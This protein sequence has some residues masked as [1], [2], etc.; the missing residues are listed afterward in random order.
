MRTKIDRRPLTPSQRQALAAIPDLKDSMFPQVRATIAAN[1]YIDPV[2][3]ETEKQKVFCRS[4]VI[5]GPSALLPEPRSYFQQELLGT[6]VLVTR[7]AEREVRAFMNV[8]RHRGALLCPEGDPVQGGRIV[9]RYHA[10]TYALDGSLTG[11][12]RQE[13]FP[14][15]DKKEHHLTSLPC[16]EAGGFIW[17]GLD[18]Q[19]DVDFATVRGE[20]EQDLDA[21]GLANMTIFDRTTFPIQANWKLV[22][23]TMLDSYHVTRLHKNS[24]ARFFVDAQNIVDAI[25]PH[26]RAAAARGNFDKRTVCNDFE[27]ARQIMVFAYTLFPN[28][29]VVCSPD[30]I[31]V[32]VLRPI[33]TDRSAVD[34]YMLINEPAADE[35][36]RDKLRRSFELMKQTFG[37]EDYW[38]AELCDKGL[39][40]GTLKE[41]QLGGMEVQIAMFHETIAQRLAD[42]S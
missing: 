33:A 6:P 17:V 9:C 13:T 28:G 23:D 22:M 29:I 19:H 3:F 37:H 16:V 38:A 11:I 41:V 27:D 12:P 31:S 15:I 20:V 36:F 34:Y 35:K 39:R 10:W 30:F 2:C 8:C 21:I 1:T 14:G 18:P 7:S 24:V 42:A 5:I 32:G 26:I 40:T 4:P 25:G